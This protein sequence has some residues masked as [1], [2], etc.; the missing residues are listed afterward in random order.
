M[1]LDLSELKDIHLPVKPDLWPLSWGWWL[2]IWIF[3]ILIV[4]LIY[5]VYWYLN[6]P[7]TYALHELKRISNLDGKIFLKEI[8]SLLKRLVIYKF[9]ST[10]GASLYG[11]NWISFLNQTKN[12]CFSKEYENLLEKSMYASQEV[13]TPEDKKLILENSKKWI[14]FNL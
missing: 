8:N 1:N 4:S 3:F 2:L 7:R 10:T 6:R 9:G 5:L 14:K 12:V 11:D 13:L